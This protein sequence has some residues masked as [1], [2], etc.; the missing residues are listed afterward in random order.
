MLSP[1]FTID[2]LDPATG[3][4]LNSSQPLGSGINPRFAIDCD[5]KVFFSNGAFSNGTLYSFNADLSLRWSIAVPNINIGGPVLGKDGTLVVSGIGTNV[6]AYRTNSAWKDL[7]F[8]MNG[9]LGKPTLCGS[10]P[11]TAG[12]NTTLLLEYA[13]PNSSFFL[14]I[15]A[16]QANLP[17]LSGTLVPSPDIVFGPLPTGPQGILALSST[18]PA[19]V[20]S[21][22]TLYFQDFI[23][24]PVGLF[25][26]AASNALSAT[27]P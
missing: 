12:S 20:P 4:V 11:L 5:G 3:A 18:W 7:G 22:T 23:A 16:S 10:S 26:A 8:A 6:R 27:T 17:L 21:G 13:R 19:G 25:G 2:R 14:F 9:T 1:A 24:D 15:G